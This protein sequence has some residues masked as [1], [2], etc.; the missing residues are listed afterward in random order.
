MISNEIEEEENKRKKSL[1]REFKDN[2][3]SPNKIAVCH[4]YVLRAPA[5]V[6]LPPV[7]QTL[8]NI[9]RAAGGV[10]GNNL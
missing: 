1:K 9:S 10:N 6:A 5:I 8:V 3:R 4:E 2:L 7:T